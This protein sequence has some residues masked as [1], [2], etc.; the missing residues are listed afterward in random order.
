MTEARELLSQFFDG[1]REV[2]TSVERC[3]DL[4]ADDGVFE[5]PYLATIGVNPRF[6]GRAAV[7]DVLNLIRSH[8][9]SFALSNI[10]IHDLKD[11]HGLFVEY[12]SESPINGTDRVYRQDY[13]TCLLEEKIVSPD[14]V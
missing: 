7:R 1:L 11:E 12:H 14:V 13:V 5:F 6:E 8:Y 10:A 4:F 3:V 9:P 2:D